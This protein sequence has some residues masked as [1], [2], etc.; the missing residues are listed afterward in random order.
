MSNGRFS[1]PVPTNEPIYGYAPGSPERQELKRFAERMSRREF[2]IPARIGGRKVRTK[3]YPPWP[4]FFEDERQEVQNV[5]E[6]GKVNYWTGPRGMEFE[7]KYADWQGSRYAISVAT[8]TAGARG[9]DHWYFEMAPHAYQ[10]LYRL[11]QQSGRPEN[12]PDLVEDFEK[13]AKRSKKRPFGPMW[14]F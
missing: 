1:V 2:D 3:P 9:S 7:K 14:K 11:A 4:H 8:G 5:L 6:E 13:I 12:L 10:E